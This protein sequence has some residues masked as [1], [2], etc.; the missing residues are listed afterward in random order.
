MYR[1]FRKCKLCDYLYHF[2]AYVMR[3]NS[4]ISRKCP[5]CGGEVKTVFEEDIKVGTRIPGHRNDV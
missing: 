5:K 1:A 4:S 3:R 2:I